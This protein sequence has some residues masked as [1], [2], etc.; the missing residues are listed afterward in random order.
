MYNKDTVKETKSPACWGVEYSR[1]QPYGPTRKGE[2]HKAADNK[3][4]YLH[5]TEI[6]IMEYN[7]FEYLKE[8][9]GSSTQANNRFKA[10][11]NR[12]RWDKTFFTDGEYYFVKGNFCFTTQVLDPFDM[13]DWKPSAIFSDGSYIEF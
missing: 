11:L 6:N 13:E 12:I 10:A 2:A 1:G 8:A 7:I 4:K 9:Y 5:I 3:Q